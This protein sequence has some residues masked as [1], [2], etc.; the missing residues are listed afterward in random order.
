MPAMVVREFAAW[1]SAR[2]G[3]LVAG[4]PPPAL[5]RSVEGVARP[6]RFIPRELDALDAHD[7]VFATA[8]AFTAEAVISLD[9][10]VSILAESQAALVV[11]G[12]PPRDAALDDAPF[13]TADAL[14]FPLFSLPGGTDAAALLRQLADEVTARQVAVERETREAQ[15]ALARA[16]RQEDSIANLAAALAAHTRL[17]CIVEDAHRVALAIALPPDPSTL[18]EAMVAAA[19]ASYAARRA[20]RAATPGGLGEDIPVQRRLQG[21]LARAIIP[22]TEG[23]V[24]IAFLSLVGHDAAVTPRTVEILWR[25]APAFLPALRAARTQLAPVSPPIIDP[26]AALLD[27]AL[28]EAELARFT[29]ER[30]GDL[31]TPHA[32]LLARPLDLDAA[33]SRAWARDRVEVLA[34]TPPLRL[35]TVRG[36]ALCVVV[37]SPDIGGDG[38]ALAGNLLGGADDLAVGIGRLATGLAGWRRSLAEAEQALRAAIRIPTRR[39]LRYDDLG[40]LQMLLPL[41]DAPALPAFAAA[42]LAPLLA[43]DGHESLLATLETFFA[44]NGNTFQAAQRLGLHRNTLTYRLNR[45]Q[46]LLGVTLDDP[47]VRLALHLALKIRQIAPPAV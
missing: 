40:V 2:G 4:E 36:E 21:D 19:L 6:R 1:L 7:V 46:E 15:A 42:T 35:S 24:P 38:A 29:A 44:T 22:L 17:G 43:G 41:G 9:A 12:L 25:V 33:A 32:L 31:S 13:V 11:S 34:R 39:R 20:V 8:D 37:T 10:L 18:T 14:A 28:P 30:H 3:R 47:E 5:D 45:I 23:E 26:L 27:G 16:R